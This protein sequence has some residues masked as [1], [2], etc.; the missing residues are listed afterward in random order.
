MC[1]H[2]ERHV[3]VRDNNPHV[4]VHVRGVDV[5]S[6]TRCAHYNSERDVVAFRFDCCDT[7]YPCHRC[8]DTVADHRPVPWPRDRFDEP[9]V[10]CGVCDRRLTVPEYLESGNVCPFCDAS[11]NPGCEAHYH[12]YFE[13]SESDVSTADGS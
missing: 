1:A 3:H 8:H 7:Y 13:Q 11:F 6:E 4:H 9:S 10:L 2:D 12:Y 5:D